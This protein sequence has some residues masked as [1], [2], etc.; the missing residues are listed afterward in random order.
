MRG[1]TMIR[2]LGKASSI[3]VRKVLWACDEIGVPHTRED[4]GS[5]FRATNAPEFLSLNPN[6]LIPVAIIGDVVLWESNSIVRY[7]AS[8]NGRDD[9]LPA[10][11]ARRARIEMWM[12]WQATE[13]NNSWRYAFQALVRKN[14]AFADPAEIAAS[15]REW[16]KNVEILERQLRSRAYI[17]DTHFTVSDIPIG[18]ALNRWFE[19]PIPDRPHFAAV[20]DYFDR[21]SARPAFVRHG[22][23]GVP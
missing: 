20:N 10:D 14:P 8:S 15:L 16:S 6:G 9:L 19:T 4:W 12:D 13:F 2:L 21:L 17:A 5:G 1:V 3:N 7:L 11:A 18:L 22:R 23:N